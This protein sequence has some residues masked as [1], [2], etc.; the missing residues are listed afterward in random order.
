MKNLYIIL[1]FVFLGIGAQAQVPHVYINPGHGGHGSDDRNIVIP[2]F[3]AGDT[4]GFWESNSNLKKGFALQEVLR[5]K[6]YRTTISRVRNEEA[7]DLGLSTIVALCNN[8]GADVFY[9]IHSNAVGYGE[10]HPYNYPLGIYRG[11]TGQPQVPRSDKL[12]SD[13]GYYLIKNQSTVW[14]NGGNYVAV[15][16]WTFRSD[17]GTQG[18]G[19][20][21]GNRAVSMLSE[22][23]HH[24]YY[25]ETY[26]LLSDQ[27][28][29][30]EG[31][32]I[33]LGADRF[34]DRSDNYTMGIVTGNVR[35][36][37][38]LRDATYHMNGADQRRPVNH[39]KVRL[40]DADGNE[41]A[42]SYSDE[43]E[44]GIYLFKYVIPGTY[45]VEASSD[46]HFTMT[47]DVEVL[48]NQ[49]T[50]CNFD[51]KRKRTSP[52]E[53]IDYSPQWQSGDAPV[54]CNIP[55]VLQFNWDMDTES[56][57]RAFSITP[58]IEGTFTWED[59]NY[60]LR[61]TP[62]DA[63]DINTLYTVTVKK[64]AMHGGEIPMEQDFVF[65]FTTQGR[66]HL[67]VLS[68][69]PNEG[70]EV[71]FTKPLVEFRSDS[72]LNSY[73]LLSKIRVVD[74]DNNVMAW[75]KRSIKNNKRGDAFGYI[76]LPVTYD[77]IVDKD[78]Y[79]EID[80]AVEDTAGIHLEAPIKVAFKVVDASAKTE[81]E[82]P[83]FE[84]EGTDQISLSGSYDEA[85]LS[86]S[87]S[88]LYGNG[89]V[90]VDYDF[91]QASMPYFRT[92]FASSLH[93]QYGDTVVLH[94]W[95]DMNYNK[96]SLVMK[97]S[98]D[99]Y[100]FDIPVGEIDFHGWKRWPVVVDSR[101]EF[102]LMGLRLSQQTDDSRKAKQ[103]TV[104]TFAFDDI[105]RCAYINKESSIEDLSLANVSVGPCPASDYLVASA[106]TWIQGVELIDVNGKC[107]ARN[108]ANYINVSDIASGVYL[109]RVY[110]DGCISLHKV[111]VAH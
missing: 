61:F 34:F 88:H 54:A 70:A 105:N 75:A 25:P 32:N 41:V 92:D 2:P 68:L 73:G 103:G 10:S 69:F 8:S 45:T 12:T 66:N 43:L 85:N 111:V 87:S 81:R 77:L 51:L 83:M 36:D 76:K 82:Q 55:I 106:D 37:R 24:D 96:L 13:L 21:R 110:V 5:K 50:Y 99:N 79:L 15:G 40:L 3:A 19:V 31:W 27:Y 23:S 49:S 102:E 26:R 108:A 35:D 17:W 64:E 65:E 4:A 91:T 63:F 29:W 71:H 93:V 62:N 98:T 22:G 97:S 11:Y 1:C 80:Q 84:V 95:G 90:S 39:A 89:A 28:C 6:G 38:L 9:A 107:V 57:E 67:E 59:T 100:E 20:L 101:G 56:V 46:E 78:Y 60:R 18:Y 48:A 74:K 42:V 30:V 14:S 86:Q 104:G 7:N 109:M 94:V 52:P 53:V 72:L 16:D 33:S 58:N 47:K 44:N